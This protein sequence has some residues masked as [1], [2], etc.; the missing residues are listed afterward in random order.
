MI[1]TRPKKSIVSVGLDIGTRLIKAAEVSLEDGTKS[2]VK[3]AH[4]E[5][6]Q[7]S[8][9][10]GIS[11]ALSSLLERF[12]P[13]LK[14]INVSISAPHSVVR[15]IDM[16]KMKKD[17]LENALSFE[18]EKYIPFN[19]NEVYLDG[20]IL[21]DHAAQKGQ[22]RIILAAAKKDAVNWRI[23]LLKKNGF[24]VSAVDID[25]FACF[26]AFQNS[27]PSTDEVKNTSLLNIGYSHTNVLI[28]KGK[29]PLFTR[30]IQIGGKDIAVAIS[31]ILGVDAKEGERLL[32]DSKDKASEVL[33][34]AKQVLSNLMDELRLSFG[35]YENQHGSSINDM[36]IS[37]GTA[38]LSGISEF[39]EEAFGLKPAIWNPLEAFKPDASLNTE[40]L[41]KSSS[42]FAISAGLAL[43]S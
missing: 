19:I 29:T 22:M 3:L 14:E 43:R 12:Q 39:V 13:S 30:D 40:L 1:Q 2:L 27:F 36:Y 20:Y 28:A 15:F 8:G 38:C 11:K 18:A 6:D 10:E 31:H 21:D 16:P 41:K 17:E 7:S 35:Y 34:A 25:S 24:S 32:F 4:Q 33:E 37:G 23:N 9:Q 26:N 5:I 42:Q